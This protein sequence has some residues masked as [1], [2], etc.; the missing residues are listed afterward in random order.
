MTWHD[1]LTQ[2]DELI[3]AED[4][5]AFDVADLHGQIFANVKHMR[6]FREAVAEMLSED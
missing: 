1:Y 2:A 6:W 3:E 5:L 4:T